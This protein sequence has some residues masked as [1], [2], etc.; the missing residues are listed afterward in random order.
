MLHATLESLVP[1]V[2]RLR[3][4]DTLIVRRGTDGRVLWPG[5]VENSRVLEWIFRR[6]DG[7]A[8]PVKTPMGYFPEAADMETQGL[9][10]H[11]EDLN[12]L[13]RV[14]GAAMVADL[15]QFEQQFARFGD[16][17]AA[18]LRNKPESLRRR[19]NKA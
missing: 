2:A 9:V 11:R 19:L 3:R 8:R 18:A 15:P 17:L 7:A 4:R 16:R 6:G 12:E 10:I 5:F 14:D 13:L 1:S